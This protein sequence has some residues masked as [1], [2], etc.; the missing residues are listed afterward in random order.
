MFHGVKLISPC[1]TCTRECIII[2][3]ILYSD[4]LFIIY[5]LEKIYI[6]IL[7]LKF[8]DTPK[9]SIN[10]PI[11]LSDFQK[12]KTYTILVVYFCS[13]GACLWEDRSSQMLVK[14]LLY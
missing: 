14:T 12:K 3:F 5:I 9:A 7:T 6:Y 1:S 4:E 13:L 2:T 8:I 10:Y 11:S